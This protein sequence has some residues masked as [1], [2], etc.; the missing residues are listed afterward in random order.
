MSSTLQNQRVLLFVPNTRW[1]VQRPWGALQYSLLILTAILKKEC[2]LDILDANINNYSEDES[3]A[4]L[5]D[6]CP[7]IVLVPSLSIEYHRQYHKAIAIA[8]QSNPAV[9]TVLGGV[10]PTVMENEALSDPNIDYVFLGHAEE[11]LVPFL[12]L[13]SANDKSGLMKFP[14][15]GFVQK[16]SGDTVINPVVSYIGDVKEQV[17]PDY[18]LVEAEKYFAQEAKDYTVSFMETTAN[19]ITSY[20]CP[21]KCVFCASRTISGR[22][23]AYRPLEHVFAEIDYLKNN[24]NISHFV[25]LDDAL[26]SDRKRSME[27][28]QRLIN[29]NY[30]IKWK[31][32]NVAAWDLNDELLTLMKQ[33][34]CAQILV[35]VESGTQRVLRE[36]IHKPLRLEIVEPIVKKCKE[37]GIVINANF[38][39]GFPG[40]TWD[41]IRETFAFAEKMDFDL[42][43]FFIATLLPKTE[44]YQIARDNKL[45][46]D[47]FSFFNPKYL[48]FGAQAVISTDQFSPQ[49]L[50][51]L[52]A[53]EW[54]RINFNTPEKRAR[55]ARIMNISLEELEEYRKMARKNCGLHYWLQ[56]KTS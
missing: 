39:V 32:A 44:L 35:S 23:V 18:S 6:K 12:E 51:I 38:V 49:E 16:D 41:E 52:R 31:V 42:A 37:L 46:P 29:E 45:I 40:E 2:R 50:M 11:R 7:D 22:K 36:I 53:F 30:Q 54:D 5:K 8:K 3:L 48:G 1:F 17:Q 9:I 13:L 47:D 15:I 56:R 21:N 27:F 20:A 34:G 43:L 33:A 25:F 26:M 28:L 4:K 10:Y 24:H 55:V 19:I 14:G